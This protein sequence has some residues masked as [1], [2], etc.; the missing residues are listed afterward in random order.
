MKSV[1]K[2]SI[3]LLANTAL[4][5]TLITMVA[6]CKKDEPASAQEITKQK[7][8]ASGSAW[9][10][11]SVDVDGKDQS[12]IFKGLTITIGDG[13][14]TTTNGGLVWPASGTWAFTSTDGTIVKRSDGTELKVSVTNTSLKL[15]LTW[16]T[17]TLGGG[18]VESVKGV[19]TFTFSL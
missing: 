9:K 1:L 16:A 13:T 4:V 2:S 12:S 11:Q 5:V 8:L 19:N 10:M 18:R 15:T 17:S 6:S 7:L 14:F 3:N